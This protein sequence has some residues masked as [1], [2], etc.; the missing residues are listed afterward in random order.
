MNILGISCYYHDAAACLVSDGKIVAAAQEERFNRDKYSQAFPINSINY[1]L[2]EA[3]ATIYDVDCIVFYEKPYLKFSR[4]LLS[5]LRFYPRTLPNFLDVMPAWFEDKLVVPLKLEKELGYKGKVLFSRH[6]LSH[7]SSA[8]LVSPFDEAAIFT[9]DGVGESATASTGY[10]RGNSIKIENEIHYPDSLGLLYSIVTTY[11]GFRVFSGEGKVMGLSAYG[12]PEYMDKFREIVDVKPDGSFRLDPDY[13]AFNKGLRMYSRKFVKTFGKPRKPESDFEQKDFDMAA[14]LQKF[15]EETLITITRSLYERTK[16]DNLC[17]AGGV[18]LNCVA[19]YRILKETPFRNIFIQPAAGDSGTALGAAI[20]AYNMVLGNPRDFVMKSAGLGPA[21]SDSVI[22]RAL[23]NSGMEFAEYGDEDLLAE[24]ARRIAD[25]RI[26]GWFQGR[27]EFGP[28]ALGKR[29]ILADPGN[30]DIK[31]ILNSKVKKREW[32]RPFAPSVL[33][34]RADE[35]FELGSPSPYMLLAP[36]VREDKKNVIPGVTHVDGTARV[37]TVSKD[38]DHRYWSLIKEFEKITGL[39]LV[40]NTSFNLR[41]EPIVC[42]PEDAIDCFKR[43]SI[44]HLV[45]GNFIA[46]KTEG[47]NE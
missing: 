11:L 40:V 10:G 45:I 27:M 24:T 25:N 32:F 20:G 31:D 44:D 8:F 19:N 16:M 47:Q 43:S 14:T 9:V 34:E 30:P 3:N 28:R 35:F 42:T 37:Q 46:S 29:S 5:H 36:P 1:C 21:Y 6:H 22:K 2:Q 26:I 39:P 41:G 38:A 23:V 17:M 4:I 15:L 33:E 7:A 13:F 18:A 12:K